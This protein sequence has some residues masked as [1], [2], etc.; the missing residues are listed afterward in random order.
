[1]ELKPRHALARGE[2]FVSVSAGE[3]HLLALTSRG[4]TFAHPLSHK[5]NSY[6]QLGVRNL[7]FSVGDASNVID[8]V[9]DV[10]KDPCVLSGLRGRAPPPRQVALAV[11]ES[12]DL[13]GCNVLFEIPAL[14][15]IRISQIATGS[16]TSF[17]RTFDG[18]VL[19][20]GANEFGQ[21]GL[22]E[23]ISLS[24]ITVPTEAVL[25]QDASKGTRTT[26]T[27]IQAGGD[28][29]VFTVERKD[30]SSLDTVDV[31]VCGNGRWGGLGNSVFSN[32]Q[33]TPVRAKGVSGL[34]EYNER[35]QNMQPIRPH[36]VSISPT[37]HVLVTLETLAGSAGMYGGRDLVV[38]GANYDYQL[39]IGK[40]GNTASGVTLHRPDGSR[41]LLQKVETTVKDLEGKVWKNRAPVEQTAVAGNKAS[42]VY[43]RVV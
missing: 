10:V 32:A 41:Y 33:S 36:A 3:H 27:D 13:E 25:W 12:K 34:L 15:G 38:W 19:G 28:L 9:P 30:G 26:C 43:W 5:A 4:R 31:L 21:I 42:V 18:R 20:W 11:V 14:N 6:G 16:R 2:K 24:A 17:A 23:S 40:R 39:G 8:L 1:V 7:E 29:S 35:M 37:G 22:G